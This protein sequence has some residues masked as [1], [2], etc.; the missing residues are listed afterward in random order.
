MFYPQIENHQGFYKFYHQSDSQL[1]KFDECRNYKKKQIGPGFSR[2]KGML[3]SRGKYIAFCDADDIWNK[4]LQDII[5]FYLYFRVNLD[6][7]KMII[8]KSYSLIRKI[9]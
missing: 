8:G 2:N 1:K 7:K 5:D 3:V 6:I 9:L 4:S